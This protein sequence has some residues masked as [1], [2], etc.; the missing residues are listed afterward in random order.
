MNHSIKMIGIGIPISQS[1]PP[2]NIDISSHGVRG[3]RL[4]MA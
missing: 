1:K 3:E 2:L 4:A